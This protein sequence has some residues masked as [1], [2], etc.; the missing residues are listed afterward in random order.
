MLYL[1]FLERNVWQLAG[2]SVAG[3]LRFHLKR[4]DVATLTSSP[5][6][7]YGRGQRVGAMT[8]EPCA[9]STFPVFLEVFKGEVK[10][11]S[12]LVS[13]NA[14]RVFPPAIPHDINSHAPAFRLVL[15]VN[16]D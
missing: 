11:S 5:G 13:G 6:H 2:G 15:S 4:G 16:F 14:R 3:L 8:A 12:L 9:S 7:R 10:N 1:R